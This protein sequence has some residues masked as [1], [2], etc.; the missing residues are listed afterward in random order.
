MFFENERQNKLEFLNVKDK[1]KYDNEIQKLKEKN[2]YFASFIIF[3][4]CIICFFSSLSRSKTI[5]R[6]R[7]LKRGKKYMKQCFEGKLLNNNSKTFSL[8]PKISAVI[9]VYNCEKTIKAAVRSIQ[10]QN[11]ADIEIILVNDNSQDNTSMII[12]EL[13][14][15]DKRIKILSNEKNMA[16]LYSRNIGI[17][18]SEGKYIMNLDN[19]DLFL[20]S[21]VFDTVYNEAE[22]GNYDIIG[23]G[24]VDCKTY[25]PLLTQIE[26]G[27]F[28]DHKDGLT[29]FQPD[30]TYFAITV[31]GE[32]EQNDLHVW[33]RLTKTELYKEAIDNFG[34]NAIG[35]K[36][37]LS[38]LTWAE[39]SAMSMALFRYAKSYKF[40]KKYGIFHYLAQTTASH[41]SADSLMKYGYLF[42]IDTVFDFS[43]DNIKGKKFS[44]IMIDDVFEKFEKD[45]Y[46]EKNLKY[47]KAILIKMLQCQY[48]STDDKKKLQKDFESLG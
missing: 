39:D 9:P 14:K 4:F 37:N 24:A 20:D 44:V 13:S 12:T 29:V 48:I 3:I 6:A 16:T 36:R 2:R 7:A 42:F 45:K 5:T 33:G 38:F 21:D 30:L 25:N 17:L 10:N 22:K 40:I 35:E 8:N 46:N 26:E 19:D 34:L 28:H 47:L 15:E 11:M 23:C 31:N 43:H 27:L 1:K 18:N 32:F 41:T